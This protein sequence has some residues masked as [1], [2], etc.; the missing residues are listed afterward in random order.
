M[1]DKESQTT[2]EQLVVVQYDEFKIGLAT[3]GRLQ[4]EV[5]RHAKGVSFFVLADGKLLNA[6]LAQVE[7]ETFARWVRPNLLDKIRARFQRKPSPT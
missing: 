1:A 6:D 4:I 7:L 5:E 2:P 3:G